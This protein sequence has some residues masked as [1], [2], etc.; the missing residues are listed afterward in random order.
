MYEAPIYS[1]DVLPR[2]HIY[3][4]GIFFIILMRVR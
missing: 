4:C 1:V 3:G 2:D